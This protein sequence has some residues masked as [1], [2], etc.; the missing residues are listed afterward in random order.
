MLAGVFFVSGNV[1]NRHLFLHA[2]DQVKQNLQCGV[3]RIAFEVGFL[4]FAYIGYK[5][6]LG[7]PFFILYSLALC[8][9]L[10]QL[11]HRFISDIV[12]DSFL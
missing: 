5:K 8:S 6:F 12:S 7:H 1:A 11:F 9:L 10:R 4:K 2:L 3:F